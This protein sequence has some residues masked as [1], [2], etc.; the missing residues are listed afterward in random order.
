MP[1][2]E[3]EAPKAWISKMGLLPL[4]AQGSRIQGLGQAFLWPEAEGVSLLRPQLSP[5]GHV[6][7]YGHR[8]GA[9]TFI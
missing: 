4:S 9:P 2:N 8:D 6:I 7:C 1:N 3:S 5:V